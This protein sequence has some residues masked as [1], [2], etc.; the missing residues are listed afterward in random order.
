[1]SD[2]I[3]CSYNNN[4][5]RDGYSLTPPSIYVVASSY[6]TRPVKCVLSKGSCESPLAADLLTADKTVDRNGYSAIDVMAVAV[7]AQAH[8]GERLANA[9]DRF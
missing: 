3:G 5:R 8:L 1:M 6:S 9:E 2:A 7:L 4:S